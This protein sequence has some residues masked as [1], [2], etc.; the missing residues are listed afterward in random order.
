MYNDII[1]SKLGLVVTIVVG[2]LVSINATKVYEDILNKDISTPTILIT[3]GV[4]ILTV[5]LLTLALIPKMTTKMMSDIKKMTIG[6]IT[7]L[8]VYALIGIIFAF[9]AN[10]LLVHHGTQEFNIHKVVL[11]L[12][13]AGL[14][15]FLSSNKK[16]TTKKIIYFILFS[17][18]AILFSME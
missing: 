15:Y 1:K 12:L 14:V 2:T 3:E 5:I 6:D 18:F 13:I 8:S 4:I 9:I 11:S 10:D 7:R 16:R 17:I